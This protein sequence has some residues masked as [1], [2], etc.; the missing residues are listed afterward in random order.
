M[1]S[2]ATSESFDSPEL[3]AVFDAYLC[4]MTTMQLVRAS[5]ARQG[6]E[7]HV[8]TVAFAKTE[9]VLPMSENL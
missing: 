2:S 5:L 6:F 9:D 8:R 4:R 1:L 7:Q 3:A